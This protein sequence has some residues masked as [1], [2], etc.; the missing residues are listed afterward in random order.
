MSQPAEAV[1]FDIGRVLIEWDL[2]HLF[3]KLIPDRE[4]LDWF[5]DNVVTEEWHFQHDAGRPLAEMV[6]ERQAQFPRYAPLIEA[7][8]T[9]FLETIAGLVPGTHLLVDRLADRGVPVF[10]LTNFGADFWQMFR[11]TQPVLDR[12]GDIVV[13]GVEKCAKPEQAIYEIAEQRFGLLP[14]QIFFA[15]DNA[16]NIAA[17]RARGWHAHH[18]TNAENLAEDLVRRG[19]LPR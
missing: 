15:D 2:R 19:L 6:P 9:R 8:A 12:F 4:E 18:F 16:A 5:L 11:P 17:A 13:S 3:E 14:Q 10:A 7:Y 1:V